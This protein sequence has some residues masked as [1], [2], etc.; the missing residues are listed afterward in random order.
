MRWLLKPNPSV[1][2]KVGAFWIPARG[3]HGDVFVETE[4]G[5]FRSTNIQLVK[6]A[7]FINQIFL[8]LKLLK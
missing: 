6:Y 2:V 8:H 5:A 4:E 3:V 7:L 1:H